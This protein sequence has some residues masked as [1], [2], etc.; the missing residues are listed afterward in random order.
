[1]DKW[2]TTDFTDCTD[3]ALSALLWRLEV[4]VM[5]KFG[6]ALIG[7][8][9]SMLMFTLPIL[10]AQVCDETIAVKSNQQPTNDFIGRILELYEDEGGGDP[11]KYRHLYLFLA[12]SICFVSKDEDRA[13]ALNMIQ[14]DHINEIPNALLKAL[15]VTVSG[16]AISVHVGH[17]FATPYVIEVI[18][19]TQLN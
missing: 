8:L 16:R 5:I 6:T 1:L 17:A 3:L 2:R 9:V 7:I 12:E 4:T 11:R 19:A 10:A 15:V 14:L 18:K 13:A